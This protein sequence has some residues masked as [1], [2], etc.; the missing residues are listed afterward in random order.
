MVEGSAKKKN[1]NRQYNPI[2][3]IY[4]QNLILFVCLWVAPVYQWASP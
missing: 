1:N 4:L 3:I 2:K